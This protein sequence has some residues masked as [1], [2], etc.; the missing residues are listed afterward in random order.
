[1]NLEIWIR[2]EKVDYYGDLAIY[3]LIDIMPRFKKM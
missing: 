1:M 2:T 3:C